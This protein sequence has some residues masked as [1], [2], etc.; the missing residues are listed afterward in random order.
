MADVG[1]GRLAELT[2]VKSQPSAFMSRMVLFPHRAAAKVGSAV[3]M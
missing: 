1:I 2:G 3:M